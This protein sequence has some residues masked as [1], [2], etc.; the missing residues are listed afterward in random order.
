M[1]L[2]DRDTDNGMTL[3][4]ERENR[5]HTCPHCGAAWEEFVDRDPSGIGTVM[6]E[7]D[8]DLTKVCP[9]R[10]GFCRACAMESATMEDMVAY[11]RE[12]SLMVPFFAAVLAETTAERL[13]HND[14]IAIW[15]AAL[16]ANPDMLNQRLRAYIEDEHEADFID[17]R[18]GA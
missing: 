2:K 7:H 8:F 16:Q 14:M 6:Y 10:K 9:I 5:I 18:C 4:R 3:Y 15:G 11:V 1:Y 17:W 12:R 13:S